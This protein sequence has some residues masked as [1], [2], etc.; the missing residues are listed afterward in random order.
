MS[1]KIER[2]AVTA[3]QKRISRDS[4]DCT[5]LPHYRFE[6]AKNARTKFEAASRALSID[7][8]ISELVKSCDECQIYRSTHQKVAGS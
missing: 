8:S 4:S 7:L 2:I 3:L 6:G 5:L 1:P